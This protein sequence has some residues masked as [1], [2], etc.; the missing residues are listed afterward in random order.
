VFSIKNVLSLSVSLLVAIFILSSCANSAFNTTNS[1]SVQSSDGVS[2]NVSSTNSNTDSIEEVSIAISSDLVLSQTVKNN[3]FLVN[4]PS[5]WKVTNI[6]NNGYTFG[7]DKDDDIGGIY[8]QEYDISE[9]ETMPTIKNLINWMLPNHSETTSLQKISGFPSDTYLLNVIT[10]NTAASSDST[11][12]TWTYIILTDKNKT[13]ASKFVAYEI[14]IKTEFA[15][16]QD[17][18]KVASTF[19]IL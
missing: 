2:T 6:G 4:I 15:S 8:R 14:F 9:N 13:T 18:L 11:T 19:K 12:E 7:K 17:A 3:S 1:Q 16:E 5:D 10:S